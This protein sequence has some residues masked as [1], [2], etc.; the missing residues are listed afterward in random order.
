MSR[1]PFNTLGFMDVITSKYTSEPMFVGGKLI[2]PESQHEE[3]MAIKSKTGFIEYLKKNIKSTDPE[4][5]EQVFLIIKTP[6]PDLIGKHRD[7]VSQWWT[8]NHGFP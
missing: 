1:N 6:F 5:G 4:T 2:I 3:F 7:Y 8:A